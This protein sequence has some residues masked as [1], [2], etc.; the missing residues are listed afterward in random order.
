MRTLRNSLL[1]AI[2]LCLLPAVAPSVTSADE[3]AANAWISTAREAAQ[4]DEHTQSIKAFEN[5][6]H[7]DSSTRSKILR[8][9][10]DQ[11][12]YGGRG[13][14]A[15][16]LYRE[17]LDTPGISPE[18]ETRARRGLALANNEKQRQARVRIQLED[19][20]LARDE[21]KGDVIVLEALTAHAKHVMDE[22]RFAFEEASRS[23]STIE[24]EYRVE[25]SAP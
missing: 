15:I 23:L 5:A 24:L 8:E 2:G 3:T 18:E 6:M 14:D 11:L 12:T 7:E 10:A 4:A 21:L 16:P 22:L 19:H 20:Y 17:V 1:A 9:Y 13:E 25:R